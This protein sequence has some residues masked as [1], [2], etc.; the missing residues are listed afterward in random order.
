MVAS[1]P[2]GLLTNDRLMPCGRPFP[3]TVGIG[4]ISKERQYAGKVCSTC[5][6]LCLV[7]GSW[8][9]ERSGHQPV[10]HAH[11]SANVSQDPLL[12]GIWCD[13]ADRHAR[14]VMVHDH[15]PQ[16]LER[17]PVQASTARLEQPLRVLAWPRAAGGWISN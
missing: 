13:N 7:L 15:P 14:E 5:S 11:E 1:Q 9:H 17:R 2:D 8:L 16:L 10:L 6:E 3:N 12:S 4:R